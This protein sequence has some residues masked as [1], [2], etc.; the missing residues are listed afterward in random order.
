MQYLYFNTRTDTA[1]FED[2]YLCHKIHGSP[3]I[4]PAYIESTEK[5]FP[6][7]EPTS[8]SP[9]YLDLVFLEDSFDPRSRIRI[10]RF[11]KKM[12]D[13][14]AQPCNLYQHKGSN[15][16]LETYRRTDGQE[17]SCYRFENYCPTRTFGKT[18]NLKIFLGFGEL[19]SRWELMHIDVTHTREEVY[20]LRLVNP[21]LEFPELNE[22]EIPAE[23]F[24]ELK[25][26]Y[27]SLVDDLFSAPESVVDHC[28]DL[29]CKL[30]ISKLRMKEE[31]QKDLGDMIKEF[32]KKYPHYE[33]V[34]NC[35]KIINRFH[36]RRKPNEQA[37]LG[38]KKPTYSCS[39]LSVRCAFKI[40][41]EFG[42]DIKQP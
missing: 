10:G 3:V 37:N 35:A 38:L 14:Q 4:L 39:D 17:V 21:F 8:S 15:E 28:R 42:W 9:N 22:A 26:K 30:L 24:I 27:M 20:T 25:S 6:V 34:K 33:V 16:I 19:K 12:I 13:G 2:G 41:Q 31:E 7:T 11:F 36:P 5:K 23:H 18:S 40:I 1:Y 32:D 29:V